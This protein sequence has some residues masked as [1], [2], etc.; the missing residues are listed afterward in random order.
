MAGDLR[1]PE[2]AIGPVTGPLTWACPVAPEQV[3]RVETTVAL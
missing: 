1:L 3:G 2:G